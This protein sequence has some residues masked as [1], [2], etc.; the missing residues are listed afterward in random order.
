MS[1]IVPEQKHPEQP[2]KK[3]MILPKKTMVVKGV[4]LTVVPIAK[5]AGV[6]TD[7]EVVRQV[8]S[9]LYKFVNMDRVLYQGADEIPGMTE[10][11]R[12]ALEKSGYEFVSQ[13]F[14]EFIKRIGT[15]E[16]DTDVINMYNNWLRKIYIT[17]DYTDPAVQISNETYAGVTESMRVLAEEKGLI[18]SL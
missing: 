1:T 8:V 15:I 3:K 5:S 10:G 9:R 2:K 4:R 12:Y 13:M 7:G 17:C 6:P 16:K 18:V 11:L 14:S